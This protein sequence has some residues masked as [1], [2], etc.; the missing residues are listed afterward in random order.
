MAVNA[1]LA[2]AVKSVRHLVYRLSERYHDWRFGVSTDA[3]VEPD[4]F[5]IKDGECH[6][7]SATNYRRFRQ[8][9]SHVNIRPG[10]DV[11]LD[12]GSGMG[13]VV[14]LAAT[15]DFRRVIGVELSPSLNEIATRNIENARSRL[16]CQNVEL[17]TVDARQFVV[18]PDA[19]V[20][21]FWS[22]F[23]GDILKTVF[24]NIRRSVQEAPRNVTILYIYAP[25]MSCLHGLMD[26]MPWLQ[27]RTEEPLGS[28][29]NLTICTVGA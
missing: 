24:E 13:R 20:F 19:T 18:P 14:M 10:Q 23:G 16:R 4:D 8:L 6:C 5:G 2:G 7:Y 21:Y 27:V 3:Y 25:G 26:Q 22:P 28:G 15:Y 12:Y 9:M 11:F 29:L 1:M 17:H